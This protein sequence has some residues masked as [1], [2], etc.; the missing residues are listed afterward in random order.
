MLVTWPAISSEFGTI[1]VARS[2]VSISV[3]RTAI[4]RTVPCL[5][6]TSIQ[7]PALIGRSTSRM[8]PET[9]LETTVWRPKP[10]P[11]DRAPATMAR[12]DRSIP[13]AVTAAIAES[14]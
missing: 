6:P 3:A 7:S 4:L 1:S 14:V 12:L 5:P 13:V 9:K 8:I 2:K 11:T 10:M